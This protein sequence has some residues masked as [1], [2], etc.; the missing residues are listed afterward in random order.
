M[1]GV[2]KVVRDGNF[3]AVVAE[4]E[5]Q[6]IKAMQA[7]A[8]GAQWQESARL[9]KQADLPAALMALPSKDMTI[10]HDA[11]APV[12][13]GKT[14]EATYTRPYQI[15]RLDR[16]ILRGRAIRGWRDDGVVA[17][18]RRLSRS[19]GHCRDAAHAARRHPR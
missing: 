14:M 11:H 8:A 4:K 5:F 13:G 15:A 12:S 17:H 6:A 18:A 1:P 2:V 9:P 3:L 10:F 19:C 16:A 7:L